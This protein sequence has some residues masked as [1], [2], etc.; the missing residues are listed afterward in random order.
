MCVTNL[1]EPAV[2][3]SV[4]VERAVRSSAYFFCANVDFTETKKFTRTVLRI[5]RC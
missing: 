1:A 2:C 3:L 5:E 4:D